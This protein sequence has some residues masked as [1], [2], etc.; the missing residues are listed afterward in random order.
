MSSSP[1]YRCKRIANAANRIVNGEAREVAA[2]ATGEVD[3][4]DDPECAVPVVASVV[5]RL[6]AMLAC[7]RARELCSVS[8]RE[9]TA[10]TTWRGM[11]LG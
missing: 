7:R 5:G 10:S 9:W 1:V 4:V 6:I 2:V 3:P 8:W 11:G